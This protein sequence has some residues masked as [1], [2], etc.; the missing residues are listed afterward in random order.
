L[1]DRGFIFAI[2][3]VRGG[4]ELG[5]HWY[6]QGRQ[7]QK[8]N[9]FTDFID[10]TEGILA[11]GYGDPARVFASGGSAGGLLMGAV[12]NMAPQRYLGV[13]AVVPFVD[14]L[15][16]MLDESIP[17]TTGEYDE[18]GDPREPAVYDYIKAYSP[19]DQVTAQAYPH[20]LVVSGLYDSQVQ[21]WEPAKWV[22]KLRANKTDDNLLLLSMDMDA[23]H[24]GKSGR[25]RYFLD[26]AQ[27]YAFMLALAD[28]SINSAS[29]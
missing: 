6:E 3:H 16:S 26:I 28:T 12:V 20:L 5:R 15:T 29:N 4:E 7:L 9:T 23:G 14:T 22:A 2:A 21:Y 1:L 24:G 18:W 25:Y 13:V 27:E 11:A 17:L 19:Y 10:A 8:M